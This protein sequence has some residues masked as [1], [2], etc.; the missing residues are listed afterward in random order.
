M[1]R[2]VRFVLVRGVLAD[3]VAAAAAAVEVFGPGV[4]ADELV[5][6]DVAHSGGARQGWPVAD[7]VV[8]GLIVIF[9]RTTVG[10]DWRGPSEAKADGG[11]ICRR[12]LALPSFLTSTP[13]LRVAI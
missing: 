12:S 5:S 11:F 9:R 10:S 6:D 7:V 13:R 4:H 2:R 8:G 3:H 1:A